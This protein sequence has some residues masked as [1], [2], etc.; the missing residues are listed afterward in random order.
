MPAWLSFDEN[1]LEGSIKN[2]PTEE[3]VATQ[4]DLTVILE[5]YS[6]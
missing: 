4:L 5:F 1:K 3:T 2:L 6:R